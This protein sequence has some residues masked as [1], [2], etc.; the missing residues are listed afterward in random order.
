MKGTV[1]SEVPRTTV[2]ASRV[3]KVQL[4]G[5]F[6]PNFKRNARLIQ[7][8]TGENFEELFGRALNNLFREHGVPVVDPT[9]G[10]EKLTEL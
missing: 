10:A 6:H 7:A 8:E 9:T 2:A 5:Y 3:G 1:E 4:T